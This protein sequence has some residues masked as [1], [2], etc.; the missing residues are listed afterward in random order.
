M[1]LKPG[2]SADPGPVI[3]D[4]RDLPGL[5]REAS[6]SSQGHPLSV[7][8]LR[9]RTR[10]HDRPRISAVFEHA[11]AAPCGARLFR[12]GPSHWYGPTSRLEITRVARRIKFH[13]AVP[14]SSYPNEIN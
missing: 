11:W 13:F 8:T 1:Y 6:P 7:H 3:E 9:R 12:P 14:S 4:R 5:Q 10:G 2:A